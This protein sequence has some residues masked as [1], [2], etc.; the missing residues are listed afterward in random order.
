MQY[1]YPVS[2]GQ[3]QSSSSIGSDL[4]YETANGTDGVR[5]Q[6]ASCQGGRDSR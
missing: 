6:A 3:F 1:V 2:R 4:S 5:A